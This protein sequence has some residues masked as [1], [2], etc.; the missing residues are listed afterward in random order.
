MIQTS[1]KR[2]MQREEEKV[3]KTTPFYVNDFLNV[4]FFSFYKHLYD[5]EALLSQLFCIIKWLIKNF[6]V[7]SC[8]H[9]ELPFLCKT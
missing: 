2:K 5:V 4:Q 1:K 3:K 6:I 7:S 8:V 9:N